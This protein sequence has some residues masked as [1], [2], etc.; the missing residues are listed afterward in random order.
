MAEVKNPDKTVPSGVNE[1]TAD[2]ATASDGAVEGTPNDGGSTDSAPSLETTESVDSPTVEG[3]AP[4][5]NNVTPPASDVTSVAAD[6]HDHVA[7]RDFRAR[8]DHQVLNFSAGQV[9]DSRV[10][11]A[12]RAT[13]SP[14]KLVERVVEELKDAL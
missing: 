7:I 4:M 14:I 12:L 3:G 9:I 2:P 10:G 13:G 11:R 8:F 5:T 6:T 1:S